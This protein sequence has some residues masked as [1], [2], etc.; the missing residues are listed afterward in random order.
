[1]SMDSVVS[2]FFP[3]IKGAVGG[4]SVFLSRRGSAVRTTL[5]ADLP[6]SVTISQLMEALF[7]VGASEA[8]A[9]SDD[10][11]AR[12]RCPPFSRQMFSSD[13]RPRGRAVLVN[14]PLRKPHRFKALSV[15]VPMVLRL[16]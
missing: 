1:M 11:I 2:L 6:S 14:T 12:G 10:A 3:G 15:A 9:L 16:D 5:K 7:L 4:V 13:E 8:A